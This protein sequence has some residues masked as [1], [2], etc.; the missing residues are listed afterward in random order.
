MLQP[1]QVVQT[2]PVSVED[3]FAA[4]LNDRNLAVVRSGGEFGRR[5]AKEDAD[6]AAHFWR[7]HS[8]RSSPSLRILCAVEVDILM[9]VRVRMTL[10]AAQRQKLITQPFEPVHDLFV[11]KVKSAKVESVKNMCVRGIVPK[12]T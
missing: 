3:T 7:M 10:V 12:R 6:A 4:H 5:R 2:H 11:Q 1:A 8:L 9:K